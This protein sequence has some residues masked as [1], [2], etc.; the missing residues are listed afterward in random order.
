MLYLDRQKIMPKP[1]YKP[2]E[3][4]RVATELK[5]ICKIPDPPLPAVLPGNTHYI[6]PGRQTMLNP[7]GRPVLGRTLSKRG[8]TRKL[9]NQTG[10]KTRKN[11]NTAK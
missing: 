7:A 10:K 1:T 2:E 5:R 11:K 6:P 4:D 9:K 8:G 3:R